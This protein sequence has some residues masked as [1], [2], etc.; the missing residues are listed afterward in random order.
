MKRTAGRKGKCLGLIILLFL[1]PG[2]PVQAEEAPSPVARVVITPRASGWDVLVSW[3]VRGVEIPQVA[4]QPGGSGRITAHYPG[5]VVVFYFFQIDNGACGNGIDPITNQYKNPTAGWAIISISV[6][7]FVQG[8]IP[9]TYTTP[10]GEDGPV[11]LIPDPVI[12]EGD[13]PAITGSIWERIELPE[14]AI[15]VNPLSGIVTVPSWFWLEL[16]STGEWWPGTDP[17]QGGQ[18]FGVTVEIP[19]PARTHTVQVLADALKVTWDFGDKSR[20]ATK[21]STLVGKPYPAPSNVQHAYNTTEVFNPAVLLHYVPRYAWNGG[22]WVSLPALY[23]ES[24]WQGEVRIREAQ[25]ILVEPESG[26]TRR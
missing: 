1:L 9:L 26:S 18:P 6:P 5:P 21:T 2:A 17:D 20:K 13:L 12:E 3:H 19:L 16:K 4:F 10:C 7:S 25:T 15:R 23:R 8:K 24:L 11:N 22:A 14:L